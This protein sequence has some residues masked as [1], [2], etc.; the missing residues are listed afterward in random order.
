MVS[1]EPRVWR[2]CVWFAKQER[3]NRP[4]QDCEPRLVEVRYVVHHARTG[5]VMGLTSAVV[6]I[7]SFRERFPESTSCG[8]SNGWCENGFFGGDEG[9]V[10]SLRN[11]LLE[12]V[13]CLNNARAV[14]ALFF[15]LLGGLKSCHSVA[16]FWS[17]WSVVVVVLCTPFMGHLPL[18]RTLCCVSCVRLP[19]N[20]HPHP[21]ELR[22]ICIAF[23]VAECI[24]A[25]GPE[26]RFTCL[27][28]FFTCQR[29]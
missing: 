3:I 24:V 13:C 7:G 11:L 20:V 10:F 14:E 8:T 22:R 12:C 23:F 29:L 2:A 5:A 25:H 15:G 16:S 26:M 9:C 27:F 28:F 19:R 21:F 1:S 6:K 17:R 4:K 18:C